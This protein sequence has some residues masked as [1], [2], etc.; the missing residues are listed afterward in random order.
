[1]W[2]DGLLECKGVDNGRKVLWEVVVVVQGRRHQ[3][4]IGGGGGSHR[5]HT[6]NI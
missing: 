5:S 6:D 2:G 1:M 3:I 4:L